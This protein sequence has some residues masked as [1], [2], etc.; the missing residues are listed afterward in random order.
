[1][2]KLKK[3]LYMIIPAFIM[4][5][6]AMLEPL[7]TGLGSFV[8]MA[9]LLVLFECLAYYLVIGFSKLYNPGVNFED[10]DGYER[11]VASIIIGVHS[12]VAILI[13]GVYFAV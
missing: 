1:M 7:L 4:L 6:L 10:D 5:A 9:R 8:V 13:L 3:Y 11:I 2:V 12:L